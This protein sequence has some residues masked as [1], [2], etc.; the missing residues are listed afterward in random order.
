MKILIVGSG[1]REHALVWKISQSKRVS[2]IFAAPGNPGMTQ[3]A[4]LVD[5]KPTSIIEL[6][7]FAQQEKIDLTVVGP[8]QP[9]ALGIVDEFNNRNLK[10][11]GPTQKAAMIETSKS[12]AKE[13][14]RKNNIPTPA[15]KVFSSPSEALDHFSEAQFPLVVKAD[16]LAAGKGVYICKKKEDAAAAVN[17]IMLEGKYG[18]SGE[19]IVVEEFLSGQEMTFMAVCDGKRVFPLATS[20]DYKKALEGDKGPNTGGMGAISPAPQIS[21]DLFDQIM[22]TI[23]QPTVAGLKFENKEFKGLLYAG[24]MI[25]R[26]GP[27]VLEFNARFGDPETQV[28]LMRL[29]SDL[30]DILDGAADENLFDVA[31]DW[32]ENV[33]GCVVLATKGYPQKVV[34]GHRIQG[35]ERAKSL[36]VEVF[37]AGTAQDAEGLATSGG[38]V[39]NVCAVAPTLKDAMAKI[40]D[41]ISFITFEDMVFRRDIGWSRK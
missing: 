20:M 13:F 35:L 4:E 39:L 36:G 37:H 28:V 3:L 31:A 25:T 29:K 12:F 15:F 32:E 11:F 1:G 22:K 26:D 8:E 24:L 30:V 10:I 18:K 33:A 21:R 14:M 17:D 5:I 23:I 27:Q 2:K 16:G 7:D 19:R 34:T 41:G 9:L 40:Y 6:A 38:R